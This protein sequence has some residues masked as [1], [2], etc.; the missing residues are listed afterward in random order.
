MG[1]VGDAV[2]PVVGDGDFKRSA[3]VFAD[4]DIH[5]QTEPSGPSVFGFGILDGVAVVQLF[6]VRAVVF[7][8]LDPAV[9]FFKLG[10][11]MEFVAAAGHQIETSVVFV[12][13]NVEG[14]QNPDVVQ[15]EVDFVQA[16][17]FGH[18]EQGVWRR[19]VFIVIDGIWSPDKVIVFVF[20]PVVLFIGK[21]YLVAAPGESAKGY[22]QTVLGSKK[23]HAVAGAALASQM[24]PHSVFGKRHL[25]EKSEAEPQ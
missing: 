3:E 10:L 9:I 11:A 13:K 24:Q 6:K 15:A 2:V 25:R 8:A 14:V 17:V 4:G 20:I 22:L 7:V 19:V 16:A 23:T 5:A 18:G 1:D 12:A 21:I